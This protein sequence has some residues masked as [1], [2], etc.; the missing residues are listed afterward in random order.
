MLG[1]FEYQGIWTHYNLDGLLTHGFYAQGFYAER[2]GVL[3]GSAGTSG[4]I[5]TVALLA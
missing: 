3:A 2:D 1:F 4:R 5:V